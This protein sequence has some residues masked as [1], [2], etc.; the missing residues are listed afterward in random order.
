[1]YSSFRYYGTPN[2]PYLTKF[3]KMF[4]QIFKDPKRRGK[5]I[6]KISNFLGF[7]AEL[8]TIAALIGYIND[9]R[10]ACLLI[11]GMSVAHFYSMEIDNS[12]V[13]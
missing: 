10:N 2:I 1:M 7:I 11:V 12:L 3:P 13:L 4:S 9:F 5:A 8:A 6:K